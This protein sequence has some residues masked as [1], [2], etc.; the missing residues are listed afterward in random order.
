MDMYASYPPN[1]AADHGACDEGMYMPNIEYS[2]GWAT[3]FSS[4][5]RSASPDA[6]NRKWASH[7]IFTSGYI[8][9]PYYSGS[10]SLET[11]K[12]YD[13]TTKR[14]N[15]CEWQ[16]A[17]ALWDVMKPGGTV[18]ATF[19]DVLAAARTRT[20]YEGNY[21]YNINE[22]WYGWTNT[23]ESR[24][25]GSL[26][27]HQEILD[28]FKKHRILAGVQFKLKWADVPQDL[29]AHL[30]RPAGPGESH[31]FWDRQGSSTTEPYILLDG[32][33]KDG[34]GPETMWIVS[35]Y[36][37]KYTYAAFDWTDRA[38][39]NNGISRSAATMLV[40]DGSNPK[41]PAKR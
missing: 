19:A 28:V 27:H 2:E 41:Y 23:L 30:F 1:S 40:Y 33:D 15:F 32:D 3:F 13:T 35:P 36:A 14:G 29:D 6:A 12:I 11:I 37:H 24:E 20:L 17:A 26:G 9:S 4:A 5:A 31:Y 16:V 10:Y 25:G 18:G 21:P 8:V 22:W 39:P 38:D 7:H 34:K